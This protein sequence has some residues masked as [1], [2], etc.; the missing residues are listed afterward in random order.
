MIAYKLIDDADV[1]TQLFYR[2]N[3]AKRR[4]ADESGVRGALPAAILKSLTLKIINAVLKDR[5]TLGFIAI[6]ERIQIKI[7]A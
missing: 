3:Q 2:G 5:S 1:R 4:N 7:I 6:R